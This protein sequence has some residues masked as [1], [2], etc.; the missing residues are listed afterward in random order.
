[1]A[2][3]KTIIK[4]VAGIIIFSV[5]FMFFMFVKDIVANEYN[6]FLF[7][8]EIDKH[9]HPRDSQL[10]ERI[11]L[12][13]NFAPASNRCDFVVAEIRESEL[14]INDIH[15]FYALRGDALTIV[16]NDQHD[17]ENFKKQYG[18]LYER[19]F[20][21]AKDNL[22]AY[23]VIATDVHYKRNNDIRCH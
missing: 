8:K 7:E 9:E 12:I 2:Q 4:F 15:N 1:M 21:I 10:I 18:E 23:L 22:N 11:S 6:L 14:P 19:V 20:D 3:R 17:M 5:L 13:G 16:S